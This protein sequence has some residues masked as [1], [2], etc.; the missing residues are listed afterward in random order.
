MSLDNLKE[1]ARRCATEPELRAQAKALGT[2]DIDGH[3]RHAGSLGLDWTAE[4]MVTFRKEVI[5]AGGELEELS[6]E[7]LEQVAGGVVAVTIA[8]V[9]GASAAVATVVTGA[10]VG[11]TVAGSVTAAGTGGW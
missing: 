11:S 2:S 1:Y 4:D 9:V 5:D 8:A 6:E 7:E 3:I 10:A